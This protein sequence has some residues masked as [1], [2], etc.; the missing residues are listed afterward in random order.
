[1]KTKQTLRFDRKKSNLIFWCFRKLS[2][3]P[4]SSL[5]ATKKGERK[6]PLDE[7]P[8]KIVA[9]CAKIFFHLQVN[10]GYLGSKGTTETPPLTTC[11][12]LNGQSEHHSEPDSIV[13]LEKAS[14]QAY[15]QAMYLTVGIGALLL[16]INVWFLICLFFCRS[17]IACCVESNSGSNM[18]PKESSV[19]TE[20]I[21]LSNESMHTIRYA[22]SSFLTFH[23]LNN[24]RVC[25]NSLR[26]AI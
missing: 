20:L 14:V 8:Q 22:A 16:G 19:E 10:R 25:S 11:F 12:P 26:R 4:C 18:G 1:M 3:T 15:Q 23:A 21:G 13:R 5:Q 6:R 9:Q 17:K 24:A 2:G 7:D